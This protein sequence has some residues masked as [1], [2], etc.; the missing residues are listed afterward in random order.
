MNAGWRR[1]GDFLYKPVMHK[2]C[3][4]QYTIRLKVDTFVPSK[5]QRQVMRRLDRY[6]LTGSIK[7]ANCV[8]VNR[9]TKLSTESSPLAVDSTLLA[10]EES[11][12]PSSDASASTPKIKY[13]IKF[14]TGHCKFGDACRFS[15]TLN[16]ADSSCQRGTVRTRIPF[17]KK[18]AHVSTSVSSESGS[19]DV[20]FDKN[21]NPVHEWSTQTRMASFTEESYQLYRKYQIAVHDDKEEELSKDGFIRFLVTSPL[22]P[23]PKSAAEKAAD[24]A[25]LKVK[26]T[27]A[28]TSVNVKSPGRRTYPYGT[29]HQE[30]RIDNK[31][32][33][34]GVLDLLPTGLSSVYF[35]YDPD[36]RDL[37][38]GKVCALKEIE[39]AAAQGLEYYYLGYFIASCP[40]MKYKGEYQ[41]AELLCPTTLQYYPYAEAMTH[42]SKFKFSPLEP[43]LAAQRALLA[44]TTDSAP[45]SSGMAS[46]VPEVAARVSAAADGSTEAAVLVPPTPPPPAAP[47]SPAV[48]LEPPAI[49]RTSA[50]PQGVSPSDQAQLLPFAPKFKL[51]TP[52]KV[53]NIAIQIRKGMEP[54]T[55]KEI[56]PQGVKIVKPMLE[57]FM[58][59]CGPHIDCNKLKFCFY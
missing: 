57:E 1:C 8:G 30:H 26:R 48:V 29:Y 12:P 3:C 13:C 47:A 33:A 46:A 25:A 44:P 15:H 55:I 42:L 22:K 52:C 23:R 10:S 40:K 37:V 58:Q 9:S 45:K 6:L 31:L 35:F 20:A 59:V 7:E 27:E 38:L 49:S 54:L 43:H 51:H 21:K 24:A 56:T 53:T 14:Q 50:L 5:E 2:T 28:D 34:V 36:Y 18:R 16:P 17:Q 19:N 41:P 11:P 4:P 39:F 32:V